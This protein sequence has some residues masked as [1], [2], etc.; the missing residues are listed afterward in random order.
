MIRNWF[1]INECNKYVYS[2]KF[3]E[4]RALVFLYVDGVLILETNIK[5]INKTKKMLTNN[6]VIKDM[7]EVDI[8]DFG[9]ENL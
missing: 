6:Y 7:G 1:T 8:S 3:K 9:N 5:V 4:T 2:K